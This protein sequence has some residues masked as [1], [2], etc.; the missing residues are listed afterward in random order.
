MGDATGWEGGMGVEGV[1]RRVKNIYKSFYK[2]I[3]INIIQY[4][5]SYGFIFKRTQNVSSVVDLQ[6]SLVIARRA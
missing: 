5:L 1:V 4:F 6:M 2:K 3:K